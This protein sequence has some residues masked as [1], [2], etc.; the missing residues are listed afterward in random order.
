MRYELIGSN[1]CDRPLS[2]HHSIDLNPYK[3]HA[4][5]YE[6]EFYNKNKVKVIKLLRSMLYNL[7]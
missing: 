1:T 7:S 2:P 4:F 6:L 5:L 3:H